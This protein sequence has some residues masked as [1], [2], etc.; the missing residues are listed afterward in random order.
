MRDLLLVGA[1]GF[2][3]SIA[4]YLISA[5]FLRPA[6][7]GGFPHGTFI[8]NVTGCFAIGM[9]AAWGDAS[10]TLPPSTRLFLMTG[11]LGGYTTFSAFALEGFALGRDQ[12]WGAVILAV[13]GQVVL[14]LLAVVMGYRLVTAVAG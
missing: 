5:I 13:A 2:I 14:G 7:P 1:G 6:T 9:I 10:Q 11:L 4:R 8:V 3:G 12:M